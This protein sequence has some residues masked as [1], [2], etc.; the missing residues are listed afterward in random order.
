MSFRRALAVL[1]LVALPALSAAAPAREPSPSAAGPRVVGLTR[2]EGKVT[3]EKVPAGAYA[4]VTYVF[5]SHG[6]GLSTSTVVPPQLVLQLK[7][8]PGDV[9]PAQIDI[10]DTRG[11]GWVFELT[12]AVL[13]LDAR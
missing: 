10:S 8:G 7:F 13:H 9:I 12:G 3:P 5:S 4:E 1:P 11:A 6:S 2:A